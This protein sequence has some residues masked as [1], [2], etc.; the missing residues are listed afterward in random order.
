MRIASGTGALRIAALI[1]VTTLSLAAC[2]SSGGPA[3]TSDTLPVATAPTFPPRDGTPIDPAVYVKA[4]DHRKIA[5]AGVVHLPTWVPVWAS[6]ATPIVIWQT[7]NFFE[8]AWDIPHGKDPVTHKPIAGNVRIDVTRE[9]ALPN[10][11][12][13]PTTIAGTRRIYTTWYGN[14]CP[15]KDV[16]RDAPVLFWDDGGYGY[17][18]TVEPWPGCAPGF[19]IRDAVTFADSLVPCQVADRSLVCETT[20]A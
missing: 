19:S 9:P 1:G 10:A 15:P 14:T 4:R 13:P 12:R 18:V 8:V 5:A 17:S 16:V 11:V 7:P 20:P 2:A 6:S 3:A